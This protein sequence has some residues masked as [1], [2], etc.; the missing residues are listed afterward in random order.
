LTQVMAIDLAPHRIR[1]NAIV[2]GMI[3]TRASSPM[4]E[5]AEFWNKYKL[6]IPMDRPGTP[7]EIA[8]LYAFLASDDAA[9]MTGSVVNYDGGFSAGIRWRDWLEL[10]GANDVR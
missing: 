1:V 5:N 3:Q 4:V 8:G 10:P 7:E 2:P 9:Y 6:K